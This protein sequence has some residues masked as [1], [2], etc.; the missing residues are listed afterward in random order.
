[1]PAVEDETLRQF[2]LNLER[3]GRDEV[4]KGLDVSRTVGWF[5]AMFPFIADISGSDDPLNQLDTVRSAM[6]KFPNRG[7]GYGIL[8]YLS[9]SAERANG[10][11]DRLPPI[12]FDYM[13][14]L[15][16]KTTE[17]DFQP[18]AEKTGPGTD[19]DAPGTL[20]LNSSLSYRMT[21]FMYR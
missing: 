5:T 1:M 17:S 21:D 8:K 7:I 16:T 13:G 14:R 3:H 6:R 20:T 18:A 9:F 4:I 19:P 11:A 10:C 2:Q 12:S 15:D